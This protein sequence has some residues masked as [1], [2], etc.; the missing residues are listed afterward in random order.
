MYVDDR[1]HLLVIEG[2]DPCR[3]PQPVA[4]PDQKVEELWKQMKDYTFRKMP[5]LEAET[6]DDFNARSKECHPLANKL[7]IPIKYVLVGLRI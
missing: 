5:E 3:A 4:T 2:A 6:I 7:D 1:V